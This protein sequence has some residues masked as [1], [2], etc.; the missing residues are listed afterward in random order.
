[1]YHRLHHRLSTSHIRQSPL[2]IQICPETRY[3]PHFTI[4]KILPN[5]YLP[6]YNPLPARAG[7]SYHVNIP[8]YT[9]TVPTILNQG[10]H[11]CETSSQA[12]TFN[13]RAPPAPSIRPSTINHDPA[14]S[15]SYEPH[16]V[17]FWYSGMTHNL[18]DSLAPYLMDAN[19]LQNWAIPPISATATSTGPS[20]ST[21]GLHRISSH[22][23]P[24]SFSFA[25]PDPSTTFTYPALPTTMQPP[26]YPTSMTHPLPQS[27]L[28]SASEQSSSMLAGHPPVP[29]QWQPRQ[30]YVSSPPST[31]RPKNLQLRL[32]ESR[33]ERRPSAYASDRRPTSPRLLR[34][35]RPQKKQP[36]VEFEPDIKKLQSR[37]KA[38]GADEQAVLLIER[39]FVTEVK[40][41]CL[42]RKLSSKE[43][44]SHQFGSESGQVYG[45]FLRAERDERYTCRL[46]PGNTD[47]SWKHKRDALRHLRR[48]H[49]GLAEKCHAW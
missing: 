12:T 11:S 27:S 43:L 9:L 10:N 15:P 6:F 26:F 23:I 37:C 2:I 44:A 41:S 3:K 47:M 13:S 39:V 34:Y 40:L 29:S 19:Y 38:A 33:R 36:P 1:M 5:R 18:H 32:Q 28:L 22:F 35:R 8:D 14:S 24:P 17:D 49:F 48:D 45:G 16:D 30:P 4:T 20:Q 7:A 31:N 42:T 25:L 46:C 21:A